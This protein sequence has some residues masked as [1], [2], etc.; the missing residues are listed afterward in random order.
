MRAKPVEEETVVRDDDRVAGEILDGRFQRLQRFHVQVVGRFVEE[1][2][3]AALFQQL[4]HVDAVALT[5]REQAHLLLLVAALEVEG[6]AIG[7]AVDLGV[8]QFDQ[9]GAAGNLFPDG[10]VGVERIA[11]LVD[12]GQLHR[13]TQRDRARIGLFLAGDH[14][15]QRRFPGAVRADHADDGA[16][17]N[18]ERQVLDQL[19]VAVM[20]AEVLD[21]DHLA[22]QT[23]AVGDDDLGLAHA[24]LL[25][26]VGHLLVGRDTGLRLRLTG[27]GPGADPLQFLFQ[28]LLL[29]L[30]LARFLGDALGLLFQPRGIIPLVGNAAPALQLQDPGGDVIQEIA[31]VRD[32][33]DGALVLDQV[34][35]QPG[36][37]L[38]IQVVGRFVE[39]QHVGR[40]QEQLAQG[41]PAAFPAREGRDIGVVGRAAQRF[42]RHIDLAIEI[43]E[44]LG[45][46]LVL[47]LRHL[48]GRLVR[49]VHRQLV[50]AVE[51]RLLRCHAQHHVAAHVE[52][53]IQRRLLRQ[54]ADL[55]A[56]GRPG[57]AGEILVDPGHDA[58]QCRFTG[59]VDADDTDL[60]TG[61]EVQADVLEA[62]LAAGVGLGHAIHVIDVLIRG[63]LTLQI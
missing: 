28:N 46:D 5:T 38:G 17:G 35:L 30:V 60:H 6:A 3:V 22:A 26:L 37:G 41:H 36:D 1:E 25:G 40:F 45:V 29:G 50:V 39:Q 42:H 61:Q 54:V 24:F 58:Q 44:V 34:L 14:A 11:R 62:F 23:G 9:L 8:A 52:A 21:L 56:L 63:H 51:L 2:D 13:V 55:G 10:R 57:L 31:V 27:L 59:A 33:E 18:A 19:A 15:E 43:P 47:Q 32:A 49:V 53:F 12:I 20:F 4:G 16:R 48:L 7:P